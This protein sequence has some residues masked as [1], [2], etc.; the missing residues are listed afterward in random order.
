MNKEFYSKH[1]QSTTQAGSNKAASYV[2]AL[3]LLCMM[4]KVEPF[5]FQDCIDIWSVN[6]VARIQELYEFVLLERRKGAASPWNTQDIPNSYLRDG[7]CSAALRS[8]EAFLVE[9]NYEQE[10]FNFFDSYNGDES[11]LLNSFSIE[12]NF[13]ENLI[14]SLE[15]KEG[16]DVIRSMKSRVNQNVFR[17]VIL[18]IYNQ[19]CCITGLNIPDINRASHIIRWADN[20]GNRLDPT[21]GLCLSATYDAAF[22]RNFISLDDDYRIILSK[23]IHDYATNESVREYFLKKE[24]HRINLP[25]KFRPNKDYLEE[26]RKH[27]EY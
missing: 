21:N 9:N 10:L 14:E 12:L 23:N 7:F 26:H 4:L 19:S 18:L 25:D 16:E 3:D 22:D 20:S 11:E 27:G 1:I 6:S 13:P 8:Y 5:S 17:K 15:N 2:R 24:G